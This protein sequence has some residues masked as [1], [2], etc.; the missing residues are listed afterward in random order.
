M[1]V[2]LGQTRVLAVVK[3]E[4]TQPYPDRGNEGSLS[5]FTEFSPMGDPA[6]EPGR[7]SEVAVEL[8]RI[9]DRGLR[10]FSHI[11]TK[12][13]Q[14]LFT[15]LSSSCLLWSVSAIRTL[16]SIMEWQ[17]EQ[18]RGYGVAMY[19]VRAFGMGHPGGYPHS[20]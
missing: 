9:I 20:G 5:I 15:S 10:Y 11:I 7:P 12:S 1:E 3:G 18:G 19:F 16:N 2:Q 17:R 6:F 13:A 8:G 14:V 4:I